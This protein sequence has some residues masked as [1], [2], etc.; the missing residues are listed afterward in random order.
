MRSELAA[1]PELQTLCTDVEAG[2]RSVDRVLHDGLL[3]YKGKVFV[4]DT[5]PLLEVVLQLAHTEAH[6]GIQKTLQRLRTEFFVEHDRRRVHDFIQSCATCQKN[7][8]EALHPAG[9]LQPLPVPSRV[10]ADIAMDFVEALPKVHGKSVILTVVDRFSKYAHFIPLGHPYTASSVARAFFHDIVRLHGFPDSIVSDRNPIFTGNVWHDLFQQ[11]GVK[12][13]MSTAFHPQT[14]GQSEAV[15]KTIAMYLRC[16]TG[17]RPRDWLDWLPWAEYCYNTAYHSALRTSPFTIV[18]GRAPPELLPYAP[19]RART[20]AVDALFSDRD[21]FLA[22]VRARLLQAQEHAR[23]FYDAKHRALEFAVGDWVLLRLLRHTQSAA[24]GRKGKLGPK[25]AGPFRVLERINEVAYRL[26]LPGGARIHDVFHVGLLKA[27]RGTAPDAP[28]ALP[29]LRH[30]RPLLQPKRVL[31]SRLS[32]G[33]WQVLV[34][35]ANLPA[36]DA[37]WEPVDDFR[38]AYPTFQLEDELFPE[39]GRDVMVGNVYKRRDKAS[40]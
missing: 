24:P 27:F 18:Y 23:R 4:P 19:G 11:A 25:F 32:R 1:S 40:G 39:D 8:T 29:P 35:W 14:D 6:E 33:A 5:S 36:A 2:A 10:W 9:L 16:L 7:K 17:D 3:L 21:E 20:D 31:R 22:E 28:P 37:T 30:G 13:R 38:A 15:N 12:L 34:Q 26:E